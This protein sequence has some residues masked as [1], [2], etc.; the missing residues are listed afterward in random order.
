MPCRYLWSQAVKRVRARAMTWSILY[1]II[2][3]L[4]TVLKIHPSIDPSS[5]SRLPILRVFE[6]ILEFL[7]LAS[8]LCGTSIYTF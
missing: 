3:F 4:H 7:S 6:S 5:P 1:V 8:V 2:S